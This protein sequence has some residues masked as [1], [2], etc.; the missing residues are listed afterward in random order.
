MM[1]KVRLL[2]WHGLGRQLKH[3]LRAMNVSPWSA[4]LVG[5]GV[6]LL[7]LHVTVRDAVRWLSPLYFL[8]PFFAI[9]IL[10]VPAALESLYRRNFRLGLLLCLIA[11]FFPFWHF[12]APVRWFTEAPTPHPDSVPL[13]VFFW[14]ADHYEF[15]SVDEA[16]QFYAASDADIIAVIEGNVDF[17][18]Q[19]WRAS[20]WMPD[21]RLELLPEAILLLHR[22]KLHNVQNVYFDNRNGFVALC[23][24]ELRGKRFYLALYDQRSNPL[25]SRVAAIRQLGEML[26][27]LAPQPVLLMGDFNSPH[28]AYGV[29]Q[30]RSILRPLFPQ[31]RQGNPYTWPEL[32]PFVALDQVWFSDALSITDPRLHSTGKAH[33]R[34]ITFT[35]HVK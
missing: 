23:D 12:S 1:R 10:F 22:G 14:T 2:K 31:F 30:L 20:E 16:F 33:H 5:V 28:N 17:G 8:T 3:G 29:G 18:R 27:P 4:C 24:I 7:L 21:Y 26:R 35:L 25:V 11:A 15:T 34:L 9:G 19:K 13:R 6:G 32:F